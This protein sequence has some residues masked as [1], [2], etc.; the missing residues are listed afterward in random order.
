MKPYR[1]LIAL[2]CLAP[3]VVAVLWFV[4]DQAPSSPHGSGASTRLDL[5]PPA[6]SN[7]IAA[8]TEVPT[9]LPRPP[10][11]PE[12]V[13]D[14]RQ[15][16][17]WLRM[18]NAN[19]NRPVRNLDCDLW[20]F[21]LRPDLE[22]FF[23]HPDS[24]RAPAPPSFQPS[25]R[26]PTDAD[27]LIAL[28]TATVNFDAA[29]NYRNN[30]RTTVDAYFDQRGGRADLLL[31]LPPGSEPAFDV[32]T[33]YSSLM[34]L[35]GTPASKPIDVTV[36]RRPGI[37]GKVRDQAGSPIV[38]AWVY[39][40]AVQ[41]TPE[42][43]RW[44]WMESPEYRSFQDHTPQVR[45]LGDGPRAVS[46]SE[47]AGLMQKVSGAQSAGWLRMGEM[48][49]L[50]GQLRPPRV[51]QRD[52]TEPRRLRCNTDGT[53]AFPGAYSATWVV[54][55]FTET[56]GLVWQFADA[57]SQRANVELVLG[58]TAL[59][60]IA[61]HLVC[62]KDET[63]ESLEL[64]WQ[65]AGPWGCVQGI[66]VA[67]D[68]F[69]VDWNANHPEADILLGGIP[70]GTWCL[71]VQEAG[72]T[73]SALV[74]VQPGIVAE[75][76]LVIGSQSETRWTPWLRFGSRPVHG[77]QLYLCGGPFRTPTIVT[78][79]WQD[80]EVGPAPI[81]LVSGEYVAWLPGLPPMSFSLAAGESR[82]DVFDI[83]AISCAFSIDQGLAEQITDER[84]DV[85]LNLFGQ[86]VFADP[87]FLRHFGA[88][89]LDQDEA[90]DILTPG[91]TSMWWLPPGRYTWA[92]EGTLRILR[93]TLEVRPGTNKFHFS[94]IDLPRLARLDVA[95][96]GAS[97]DEPAELSFI[98][99][100]TAVA[101]V[102]AGGPVYVP[103]AINESQA[104]VF[105][106]DYGKRQIAFAVPG[107]HTASVYQ[108]R[109]YLRCPVTFPGS[110]SLV[111]Q[112]GDW[113]EVAYLRL[114]KSSH[115]ELRH[116]GL[117]FE[118]G[119]WCK[120]VH[121]SYTEIEPG[122][123][124]MLI[125]RYTDSS[126]LVGC[127]SV[128]FEL[129]AQQR[130]TL[131]VDDLVYEAPGRVNIRCTGRGDPE[132]LI[133]PW[134]MGAHSQG[135][136]LFLLQSLD[137]AVGNAPAAVQLNRP[138]AFFQAGKPS[139]AYVNRP[140]PPGRYRAIPWQGAPEK[141]CRTFEVKPGA[142]VDIAIQGG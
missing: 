9:S 61:L 76:R 60:G 96:P 97:E 109:K 102:P 84:L 11:A 38:D 142:T 4:V 15:G 62:S 95:V 71:C 87:E 133:D 53:F 88:V 90:Y 57:T 126:G 41:A 138:D 26:R 122:R 37:Y 31:P 27:G 65:Q 121:R 48:H 34:A 58:P 2:V 70:P 128:E 23:E 79:K 74:A 104:H 129:A 136:R 67:G 75:V 94:L 82:T 16:T 21:C 107:V 131:A 141:Y 43:H 49:S 54:A 103:K 3:A 8:T 135:P 124:R 105:S 39:A 108:G 14:A 130:K 132:S 113:T 78:I 63:L 112:A 7:Q 50:T 29:Q 69:E 6:A 118:A 52:S 35:A 91:K 68:S 12:V 22:S 64:T 59:G 101:T 47:A 116:D 28:S 114:G 119:G 89:L 19:S 83:P 33:L 44:A 25:G 5:D 86:D 93:G 55:A 66:G 80:E 40:F 140:L 18:I 99:D 111:P 36:R 100:D 20:W 45:L 120:A 117:F 24:R 46:H 115:E 134:W 1:L 139:F 98:G 77:G 125:L 32:G 73:H 10:V 13:N 42:T 51:A 30:A 137:R 72:R 56:H 81:T 123:V 106:F 85:G 92:L 127:A 17:I 110:A